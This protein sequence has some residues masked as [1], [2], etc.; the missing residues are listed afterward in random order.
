MSVIERNL[1]V[2]YG[3]NGIS[4]K[5]RK[6]SYSKTCSTCLFDLK[7]GAETIIDDIFC[8]IDEMSLQGKAWADALVEEL[9]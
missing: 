2:C 3:L 4:K 1:N 6:R 5:Q 8:S 9:F 7:T